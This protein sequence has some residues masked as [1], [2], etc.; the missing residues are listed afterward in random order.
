MFILNTNTET[1][2]SGTTDLLG[3]IHDFAQQQGLLGDDAAAGGTPAFVL[4]TVE[5]IKEDLSREGMRDLLC[6]VDALVLPTR[7]EGWGL[8]VTE[9]MSMGLPV[10]V[11]NAS[12]PTEYATDDNAYL[13]RNDG[14]DPRTGLATPSVPHLRTLMRRVVDAR[15]DLDDLRKQGSGV[16]SNHAGPAV[17]GSLSA[18]GQALQRISGPHGTARRTMTTHYDS[19]VIAAAMVDSI[20]RLH[21]EA[22]ER[23]CP[24]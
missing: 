19:H 23:A 21:A 16:N 7:G 14:V 12:G 24:P 6:H 17:N 10:I 15:R 18:N 22:L 8:P 13:L 9:A 20:R 1:S 11:T 5:W 3:A 4:P 2:L